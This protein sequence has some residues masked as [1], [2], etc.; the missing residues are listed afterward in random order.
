VPTKPMVTTLWVPAMVRTLRDAGW[1]DGRIAS[2]VGLRRDQIELQRRIPLE[3]Y[4]ALLDLAAEASGDPHF[5]LHFGAKHAFATAGL[6]SYIMRN[7]PSLGAA[8][9]NTMR[10]ARL[11]VDATELSLAFAGPEAR[12]V[13]RLTDPGIRPSRH[14]DELLMVCFLKLFRLGI[15]DS[16]S[17]HAVHFR[18]GAPADFAPH[19]GLFGSPVLFGES[20]NAML[21]DR[22]LLSRAICVADHQLLLILEEHARA[23]LSDLPAPDDDLAGRLQRFLVATLPNEACGLSA[24]ARALGMSTRTL[25]RRLRQ[26]GIV[27]ARLL[28]EVRRGLSSRYLAEGNL[29]LGEIAYLLGYSESSAFNRAYRRW[30]G[31]TPSADRRRAA[32]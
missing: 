2:G 27:Y 18:H 32:A 28:D 3:K 23:I 11:H 30:T 6:L 20:D 4:L 19:Q 21:F 5:G 29:S 8:L 16:W 15:D 10:Y 22:Q 25:Q 7:S 26:Q 31:R 24:A 1:S 17:P 14:Y 9:A 13:Y 12:L